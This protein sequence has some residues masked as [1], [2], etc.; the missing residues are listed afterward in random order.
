MNLVILHGGKVLCE[1]NRNEIDFIHVPHYFTQNGD[2][3][4]ISIFIP[5][6]LGGMIDDNY[7]SKLML[8]GI[9]WADKFEDFYIEDYLIQVD[10]DTYYYDLDDVLPDCANQEVVNTIL[11]NLETLPKHLVWKSFEDLRGKNITMEDYVDDEVTPFSYSGIE[12]YDPALLDIVKN[13]SNVRSDKDALLLYS[14]GKD[15]TLAAIRLKDMGYNPYFIHFN[16]GAMLDSDKPFLT[17]QN[18]FKNFDGYV[19]PYEYSNVDIKKLF[20]SYFEEWKKKNDNPRLTSEIRCLSCRMAMYTKAFDIAKKKKFKIISEGARISQK[21]FIEQIRFIPNLEEIAEE[22]GIK[23]LFPV[24]HLD[25]D[26][27]LIRELIKSGFS[28]KTWES[29]CLLGEASVER[30]E[31]DE[32]VIE[33]YYNNHIRPKILQHLGIKK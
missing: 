16:N 23:L 4:N 18:T 7:G 13:N 27:K 22:L 17:F 9:T 19:F 21:F 5:L 11:K 32:Q 12:T 25:D 1:K 14:G 30:C 6:L 2:L 8:D 29:K 31:K 15:S 26:K 10:K 3:A 24:L 20:N 28:S 33:D